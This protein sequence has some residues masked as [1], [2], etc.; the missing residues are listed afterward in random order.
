MRTF[1]VYVVNPDDES[2]NE[3]NHTVTFARHDSNSPKI[4]LYID[5]YHI[6]PNNWKFPND[7]QHSLK[8]SQPPQDHH[9]MSLS[10]QLTFNPGHMLGQGTMTYGQSSQRQV[11]LAPSVSRY[12]IDTGAPDD[13]KLAY[14][15]SDN[16]CLIWN[17]KDDYWITYDKWY[18]G[19]YFYSYWFEQVAGEFKFHCKYEHPDSSEEKTPTSNTLALVP[20]EG[21]TLHYQVLSTDGG[22]NLSWPWPRRFEYE[23]EDL[24]C[25]VMSGGA[26]E[27]DATDE[28]G[29]I[30]AFTGVSVDEYTVGT[31][32]LQTAGKDCGVLVIHPKGLTINGKKAD[33]LEIT[34]NKA[35]WKGSAKTGYMSQ[36]G[37]VEF[38]ECKKK[39]TC[40][41]GAKGISIA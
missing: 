19:E 9:E 25:K 15:D 26:M 30:E 7:D 27:T 14:Y 31:Y 40:S 36:D 23:F 22:F 1:L 13:S 38:S 21:E 37:F 33:G 41:S 39:V 17:N 5:G 16:N 12:R 18:E 29:T 24:L 11:K 34:G 2:I 32:S 3:T 4:D 35:S 20:L 6:Y 8:Y 28:T 10:G